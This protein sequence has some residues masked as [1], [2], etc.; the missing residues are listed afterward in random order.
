MANFG[1]G[2]GMGR[3]RDGRPGPMK[4]ASLAFL[5]LVTACGSG[6]AEVGGAADASNDAPPPAVDAAPRRRRRDGERR[7]GAGADPCAEAGVP[8]STLACTGLYATLPP[9]RSP[10]ARSRT[11]R[12]RRSGRTA[13]R[14][15][16]GSSC[17]RGPRSTSAI[18]TSGCSRSGRSCSRSFASNGK[19]VE[20]RMFQKVTSDFWVYATYAWNSDDSAATINFGGPV[21]VGDGRRF[22]LEHTDQRRLRR[23]PSGP[24]GPDP[25]LRAGRPRPA[26]AR[27]G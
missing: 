10:P 24:A 14:S 21:P 23:M 11:R 17:R 4:R 15:S 18:P 27:R 1:G 19:R 25:R 13:R 12:P 3:R 26:R 9:R 2:I 5:G 20:T 8:A 22:D 6:T 7:R 16:A